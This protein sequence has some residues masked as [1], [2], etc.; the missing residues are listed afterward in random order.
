[1]GDPSDAALMEAARRGELY[2]WESIVRRYQES[3]FRVAYLVVRA[4]DLA[5]KATRSTFIRAYRALPN[6]EVDTPPLP[7]LIRIVAGEARQQR[8]ES[9]RPTPSS[10][11]PA[12]STGPQMP[13]TPIPGIERAS[14]LTPAER[15]AIISAFDRLA[16]EDR[17]TIAS[18]YLFGLSNADAAAALS[19]ASGLVDEHLTTAMQNLRKR[20]VDS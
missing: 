4:S 14:A 7:W 6:L 1:M 13:A 12:R 18:R 8:R 15:G 19:I 5:E 9:G 16:E 10:R 17:M 20:L 2:A 11:P 3:V